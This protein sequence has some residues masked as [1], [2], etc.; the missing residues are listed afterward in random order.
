MIWSK[1]KSKAL[2]GWTVTTI[3]DVL[4]MIP[5]TGLEMIQT[6]EA[7]PRLP[8]LDGQNQSLS[9]TILQILDRLS[10]QE[11]HYR[12][13]P[14]AQTHAESLT[15]TGGANLTMTGQLGI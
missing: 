2:F 15:K 14:L 1:R 6:A 11:V 3:L 9:I 5:I 4:S 12:A 10:T 7:L 13:A 8:S